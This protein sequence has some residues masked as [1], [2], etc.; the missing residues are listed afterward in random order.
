MKVLW[1]NSLFRLFRSVFSVVKFEPLGMLIMSYLLILFLIIRCGYLYGRIG[2][3]L[4]VYIALIPLF[5][6]LFLR[7][8]TGRCRFFFGGFVPVGCPMWIAFVACLLELVSYVIRPFVM[9]FRPYIN[10]RMGYYCGVFLCGLCYEWGGLFI[11]LFLFFLYEVFV[12]LIHWFI[13]YEILGFS[14]DH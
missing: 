11:F 6:A 7:N 14:V 3:V 5:L 4:L 10:L 8:V 12:A 1:V 2:Y 9:L 13:V